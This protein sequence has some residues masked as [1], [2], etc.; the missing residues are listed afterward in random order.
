MMKR[1]L[2]GP[3]LILLAA[4]RFALAQSGGVGIGTTTP[5]GSAALEIKSTTKG[6]LLPRLSQAQRDAMGTGS[7]AAPVPGLVV[8]QTDNTPGLYAYDGTAWVRLGGDNLGNHTATQAVQLGNNALTGDGASIGTAVG[9]GVRTDGGLNL[10][11]NTAGNN[12][13]V[14][15]QAGGG[16]GG[17]YNVALGV[18][19]D[20][21]NHGMGNTSIGYKAAGMESTGL[22]NTFTGMQSGESNTTGS[23]NIFSGYLSG[24]NNNGGSNNVFVGFGSGAT[25]VSGSTN[26]AIGS[27][28]GP[29]TSNLTNTTAIGYGAA[30]SQ[31]KSLVLGSTGADA[32]KVGIGTTAPFTTLDVRTADVSAAITVGKTDATAGALYLGNPSHGLKRYYSNG[33]DVGLFTT[34]GNLYLSANGNTATNQFALISNGG[35]GIGT[36]TPKAALQLT[37]A[38]SGLLIPTYATLALANANSLP[39]LNS[40]DHKGLMIYVDEAANQGFWFYNGTAFTKVGGSAASSGGVN[41]R[42]HG[43]KGTNYTTQQFLNQDRG[44]KTVDY[45]NNSATPLAT[46]NWNSTDGA[47]TA[48][49]AGLYHIDYQVC[50]SGTNTPHISAQITLTVN[51]TD[52][53]SSFQAI[54]T[55]DTG[56]VG[57]GLRTGLGVSTDYYLNAGDRIRTKI[58]PLLSAYSGNTGYVSTLD[59][60]LSDYLNV[61]L[62]K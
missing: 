47:Y 48:P 13:A 36:S 28:S 19:S 4:P 61:R 16:T 3:L 18:G 55:V 38:S 46:S 41:F 32:V 7:I 49:V 51:D 40:T 39:T 62:I 34:S 20:R 2:L 57:F 42:V 22:F 53:A 25:N 21:N 15:Y 50:I 59:N 60:S 44:F 35:L 10:G 5:D 58:A 9:V 6:L 37:S 26:T 56:S 30:V 43:I 17:M 24:D 52:V 33:N 27:A 23:Y 29:T 45:E 14:G 8:Y 31:S 11:Q 1:F 54:N 12:V